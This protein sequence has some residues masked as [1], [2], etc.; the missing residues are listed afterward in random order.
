MSQEDIMTGDKPTWWQCTRC[1]NE[2]AVADRKALVAVT[3]GHGTPRYCP[4]CGMDALRDNGET[5]S[6]E[7]GRWR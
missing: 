5:G 7:I 6:D 1:G 4:F 3:H 2:F